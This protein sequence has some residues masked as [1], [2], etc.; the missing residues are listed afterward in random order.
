M[1]YVSLIHYLFILR[2]FCVKNKYVFIIRLRSL[3]NPLHV[4]QGFFEVIKKKNLKLLIKRF[5]HNF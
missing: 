1:I 3:I 2:V 5:I 4:K